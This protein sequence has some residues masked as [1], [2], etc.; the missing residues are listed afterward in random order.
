MK[1]AR[2]PTPGPAEKKAKAT[3]QKFVGIFENKGWLNQTLRVRYQ[4]RKYRIFCSQTGFV[5]YRINDYCGVSPGIPGWPVCFV[6]TDQILEEVDLSEFASTEP[7]AQEWFQSI[8]DEV[9][10]FI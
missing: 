1:S 2:K 9:L 3:L 5:A 10:E 6:T 4:G 8:R 7:G